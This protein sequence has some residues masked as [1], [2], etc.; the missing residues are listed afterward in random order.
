MEVL[1]SNKDVVV[2]IVLAACAW[3]SYKRGQ[4]EG[5]EEGV[6]NT[7]DYLTAQGFLRQELNENGETTIHKAD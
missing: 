1:F 5:F 3:F 6:D 2:I 7:L 4:Q